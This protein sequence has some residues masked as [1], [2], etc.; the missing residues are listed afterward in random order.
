MSVTPS[1]FGQSDPPEDSAPAARLHRGDGVSSLS[2]ALREVLR[3]PMTRANLIQVDEHHLMS[4]RPFR[5]G[6]HPVFPVV[7]GIPNFLPIAR[8]S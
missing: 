7:D 1:Q 3:C 5:E 8:R 6:V 4:E 2:P